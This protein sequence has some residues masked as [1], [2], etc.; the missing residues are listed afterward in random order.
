MFSICYYSRLYHKEIRKHCERLTKI[1]PF[2]NKDNWEGIH[3][4]R[5]KGYWKK[6]EKKL[7]LFLL[8]FCMF[9]RKKKYPLYV[10]KHY[11][12]HEKEVILLMIPNGEGRHYLAAKKLLALLRGI[13]I[14]WAYYVKFFNVYNI[15]IWKYRM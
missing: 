2:I 9:E 13:S 8:M 14:R 12:N 5:G 15:I 11:W 1:K 7:K 10:S 6:F 3:F 4:P